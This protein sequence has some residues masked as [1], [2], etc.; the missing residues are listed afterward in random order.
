[1]FVLSAGD[2]H[3]SLLLEDLIR[4][5][6]I[7]LLFCVP[8]YWIARLLESRLLAANGPNDLRAR[9]R[10]SFQDL[11]QNILNLSPDDSARRHALLMDFQT[12]L[13]QR[14][15]AYAARVLD[16]LEARKAGR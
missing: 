12:Y 11:Q 3:A 13:D 15:P 1:L 10:Q 6:G 14:S 8:G 2:F 9:A 16:Q 5:V 4:A 7:A